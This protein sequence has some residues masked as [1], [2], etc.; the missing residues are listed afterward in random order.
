MRA[1]FVWHQVFAPQGGARMIS[2]QSAHDTQVT[3]M[4]V[5]STLSSEVRTRI[6]GLLAQLTVNIVV[7]HAPNTCTEKEVPNAQ[8][9]SITKDPS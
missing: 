6:A 7:A 5:W 8:S 2:R 1:I 4:Q 9:T 3:P